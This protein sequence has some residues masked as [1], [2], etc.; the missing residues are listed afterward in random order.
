MIHITA[1][2]VPLTC[3]AAVLNRWPI[4][5]KLYGFEV[6]VPNFLIILPKAR[7]K[8]HTWK[9]HIDEWRDVVW[10]HCGTELLV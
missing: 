8:E 3:K 1:M 2:N 10:L 7:L 6:D 9:P 5:A 4:I